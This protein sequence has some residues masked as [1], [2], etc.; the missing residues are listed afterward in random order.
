MKDSFKNKA[1]IATLSHLTPRRQEAHFCFSCEERHLVADCAPERK[2][3]GGQ[4]ELTFQV[5]EGLPPFPDL[6]M[7][8]FPAISFLVESYEM[9]DPKF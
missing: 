5:A 8:K 6:K 4:R 7:E 3:Q 9:F 2:A 1:R